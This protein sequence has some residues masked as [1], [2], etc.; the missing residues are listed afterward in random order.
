VTNVHRPV[1]NYIQFGEIS[2]EIKQ[3]AKAIDGSNYLVDQREEADHKAEGNGK[4]ISFKSRNES[5]G[6]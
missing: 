1:I 4:L 3:R 5:S 2:A 6:N